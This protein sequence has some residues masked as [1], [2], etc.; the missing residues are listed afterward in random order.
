MTVLFV[1]WTIHVAHIW[2]A[3]L[4]PILFTYVSTLTIVPKT[5]HSKVSMP[6]K[7]MG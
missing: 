1:E 4:L 7:V 5:L 3:S 2:E 6:L